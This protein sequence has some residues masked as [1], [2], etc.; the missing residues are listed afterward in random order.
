MLFNKSSHKSCPIISASNFKAYANLQ[1]A[2][3]AL[4]RYS[5]ENDDCMP[6]NP[7][8]PTPG[9]GHHVLVSQTEQDVLTAAR[10]HVQHL[11]QIYFSYPPVISCLCI[12]ENDEQFLTSCFITSQ[13]ENKSE[14]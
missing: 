13:H 7:R 9:S 5:T 4:G 8:H 1:P 10:V 12:S 2:A 14:K 11:P 3:A 6:T